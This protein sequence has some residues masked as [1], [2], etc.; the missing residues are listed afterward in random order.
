[1][2]KR[3]DTNNKSNGDGAI[4]VARRNNI[5]KYLATR[6]TFHRVAFLVIY[7]EGEACEF[8]NCWIKL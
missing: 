6:M 7:E 1:L 4:M 3:K 2:S 8:T 5:I